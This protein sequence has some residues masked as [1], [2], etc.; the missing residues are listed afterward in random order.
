MSAGIPEPE[1]NHRLTIGR[2]E[3][4]VDI[5]WPEVRFG[6]EYDGDHHRDPRSF[7]A[8]I[9]RQELVQDIGWSLMRA[10]RDDLFRDPQALVLRVA[11]RLAERG[12]PSI[13]IE[14]SQMVR[15]RP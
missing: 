7:A 8:D 9:R 4:R 13:R 15:P 1:L 5:A 2:R 11:S 12:S 3:V 10:T 14:V 6:L